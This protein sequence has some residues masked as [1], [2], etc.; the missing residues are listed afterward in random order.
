VEVRRSSSWC[1]W[2]L[3]PPK[4]SGRDWIR[5]QL[6]PPQAQ[7]RLRAVRRSSTREHTDAT[8]RMEKWEEARGRAGRCTQHPGGSAAAELDDRGD[9]AESKRCWR[10]SG[11]EFHE[12]PRRWRFRPKGELSSRMAR[13]G[14]SPPGIPSVIR[15]NDGRGPAR[16][17]LR[18]RRPAT[19][20][21]ATFERLGDAARCLTVEWRGRVRRRAARTGQGSS[22]PWQVHFPAGSP[23]VLLTLRVRRIQ[24]RLSSRSADE[25]AGPDGGP[26]HLTPRDRTDITALGLSSEAACESGIEKKGATAYKWSPGPPRS[27]C[28]SRRERSAD[29]PVS[30][31]RSEPVPGCGWLRLSRAKLWKTRWLDPFSGT[32]RPRM[33][34][35]RN[36]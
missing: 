9:I 14:P 23:E 33:S 10:E 24:G 12:D 19:Y 2:T 27:P 32:P 36:R 8:L 21:S 22:W 26:C 3:V 25:V 5:H 35:T 34:S 1:R 6:V 31:P 20:G 7:D 4:S 29:T 28:V 30:D 16:P 11:T 15:S 18:A 17:R 13:A